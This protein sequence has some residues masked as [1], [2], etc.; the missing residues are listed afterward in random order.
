MLYNKENPEF[1]FAYVDNYDISRIK[2]IVQNLESE[3]LIDTS[4]QKKYD[5]H[6]YTNSYI[7]NK[8][9]LDWKI[10]QPLIP[11]AKAEPTELTE[12]ALEITKDLEER[13]D[14]TRG[15]VL[16]IKLAANRDITA[17]HDN[18]DYLHCVARNHIPIVT[19]PGVRFMVDHESMH[20][21]EGECWEINNNKIHA[22]ENKGKEDRIHLL[23]DIVPNKYVGA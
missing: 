21:P 6:K 22:V 8:V 11:I 17:H 5:T 4:R 10:G 16:F 20:I 9:S 23:I 14:G 3:W 19:N 7:V 18:G 1:K 15:Q 12:L 13:L 2:Q